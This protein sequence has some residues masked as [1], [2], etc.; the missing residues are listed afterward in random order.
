MCMEREHV[1]EHLVFPKDNMMGDSD[2][3]SDRIVASIT[4]TLMFKI[5]PQEVTQLRA[6]LSFSASASAITRLEKNKAHTWKL[7][8][9]GI[10]LMVE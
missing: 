9:E 10:Q 6:H 4:K 1:M 5:V 7:E 8:G 2:L 3:L